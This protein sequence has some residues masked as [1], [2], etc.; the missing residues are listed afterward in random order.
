M[1]VKLGR[2][3]KFVPVQ[4]LLVGDVER[5]LF[6]ID[7]LNIVL[8]L[9]TILVISYEPNFPNSG[10]YKRRNDCY[11]SWENLSLIRQ[12]DRQFRFSVNIWCGFMGTRIV[13]PCFYDLTLTGERYIQHMT[14][15]LE[16]FLGRIGSRKYFL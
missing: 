16:H 14:E 1:R 13:G 12:R 2:K 4:T 6:A 15:I 8:K 5:R 10:I 3:Y 11:W 9:K 7:V